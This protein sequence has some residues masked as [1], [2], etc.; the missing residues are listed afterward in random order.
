MRYARTPGAGTRRSRVP[1]MVYEPGNLLLS[2]ARRIVG[3]QRF[4]ISAIWLT[5]RMPFGFLGSESLGRG[6][7]GGCDSGE[8]ESF[9]VE[10]TLKHNYNVVDSEPWKDNNAAYGFYTLIVCVLDFIAPDFNGS[11]PPECEAAES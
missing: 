6:M 8:A 10:D 7:V 11:N 9:Q 4:N 3:A 5:E 1:G 2:I